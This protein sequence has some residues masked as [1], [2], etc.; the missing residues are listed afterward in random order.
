[1]KKLVKTKIKISYKYRI[2]KNLEGK[3]IGKSLK[4]RILMYVVQVGK[5]N[6][7][8]I[9]FQNEHNWSAAFTGPGCCQRSLLLP[10]PSSSL[11][12]SS[13]FFC[14]KFS[15]LIYL[16]MLTYYF[17][18]NLNIYEFEYTQSCVYIFIFDD[19]D[20][21]TDSDISRIVSR[22]DRASPCVLV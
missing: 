18:I 10:T 9:H 14:A 1:M 12:P 22:K 3:K 13:A 7:Q 2:A 17:A 20:M 8:D 19:D 6:C 16:F 5:C 15:K 21:N 4:K 11:F